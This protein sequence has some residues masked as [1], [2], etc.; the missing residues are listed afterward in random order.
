MS[1]NLIDYNECEPPPNIPQIACLHQH[2]T[3]PSKDDDSTH[4][5]HCTPDP[6]DFIVYKPTDDSPYQCSY[7][8]GPDDSTYACTLDSGLQ[9]IIL[10]LTNQGATHENYRTLMIAATFYSS[11]R[12]DVDKGKLLSTFVKENIDCV[13]FD[14][15]DTKNGA[16][17]ESYTQTCTLLDI[18]EER[19]GK[20]EGN[21]YK[22]STFRVD[23]TVL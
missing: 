2:Y 23:K 10:K 19:V 11:G 16:V 12:G 20:S 14:V 13:W 4:Q 7:Q 1:K 18:H 5:H 15:C 9:R 8:C 22:G 21:I 6:R 3:E 17:V